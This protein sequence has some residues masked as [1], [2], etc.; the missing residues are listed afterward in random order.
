MRETGLAGDGQK[1]QKRASSVGSRQ[2]DGGGK[3]RPSAGR[4]PSEEGGPVGVRARIMY[5]IWI[6]ATIAVAS[7]LSAGRAGD[8]KSTIPSENEQKLLELTNQERKKKELPPL[9]L[10]PLLSKVAR[11]HSENMARQGKMEHNL[12]GKTPLDRLRAADYQFDRGGENIAAGD[13]GISMPGVIKAWMESKG[14]RET[15]LQPDYTEVGVG[16]ARDK[17]GQV[18]YTQLFARPRDKK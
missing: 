1:W 15:I 18:Y 3:L 6:L 17:D 10:S 7:A 16:I 9:A 11:A 8:G 5:R 2:E 13:P 14:H 12:D 4:H